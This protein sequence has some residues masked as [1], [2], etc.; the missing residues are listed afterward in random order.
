MKRN[1]KVLEVIEMIERIYLP[2]DEKKR[3]EIVDKLIKEHGSVKLEK[4]GDDLVA[5]VTDNKIKTENLHPVTGKPILH[6]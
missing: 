2:E 4:Y 5:Y 1:Q 6:D 3:S